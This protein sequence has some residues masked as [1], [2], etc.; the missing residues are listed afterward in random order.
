MDTQHLESVFLGPGWS[1]MCLQTAC[2]EERAEKE[3]GSEAEW[4][5]IK[6]TKERRQTL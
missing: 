4:E 2:L 3:M 6:D 1:V 5:E